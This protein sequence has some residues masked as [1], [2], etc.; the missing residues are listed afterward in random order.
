MKGV[1]IFY[2]TNKSYTSEGESPLLKNNPHAKPV[3]ICDQLKKTFQI[4]IF[5]T[6]LFK[7]KYNQ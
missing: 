5:L 7:F 6:K 3:A 1:I 2:Y 4:A